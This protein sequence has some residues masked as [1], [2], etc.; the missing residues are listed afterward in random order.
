MQYSSKLKK[1]TV[2]IIRTEKLENVAQGSDPSDTGGDVGTVPKIKKEERTRDAGVSKL[3]VTP[4]DDLGEKS[5]DDQTTTDE[6]QSDYDPSKCDINEGAFDD[7]DKTSIPTKRL[8]KKKRGRSCKAQGVVATTAKKSRL[9]L[10][11]KAIAKVKRDRQK[12]Y[13]KPKC[14]KCDY[15][16][17]S[18]EKLDQHMKKAHK[19]NTVYVCSMCSFTC[20][21][22]REF[23]RHMKMHFRGPP[24]ECDFE[25]CDYVVDRIQPLLYHRMVSSH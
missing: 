4:S 18:V 21:W 10:V 5:S 6:Q 24:Y 8:V 9:K 15:I 1:D 11:K 13:E 20:S 16:G 14:T 19:D 22:N 23:Y 7:E 17:L 25:A 2:Q 12:K 3:T